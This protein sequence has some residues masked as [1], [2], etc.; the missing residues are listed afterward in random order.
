MLSFKG[1]ELQ[2]KLQD[3]MEVKN[4]WLGPCNAA[5]QPYW[6]LMLLVTPDSWVKMKL[7]H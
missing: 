5:W 6:R 1:A 4:E 7:G 3:D 2:L